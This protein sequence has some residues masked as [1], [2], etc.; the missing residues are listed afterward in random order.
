MA[1]PSPCPVRAHSHPICKVR[2]ETMHSAHRLFIEKRGV[3]ETA[4]WLV[5][6][7]SGNE[8]G[9]GGGG[10]VCTDHRCYLNVW[11]ETQGKRQ[12]LQ[13]R[14]HHAECMSVWESRMQKKQA[15]RANGGNEHL[16][17]A[18]VLGVTSFHLV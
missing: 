7:D 13:Y 5:S 4:V 18:T 16:H 6:T 3:F 1:V 11:R 8:G 2:V 9:G 15:T 12:S 10:G 17:E 14:C